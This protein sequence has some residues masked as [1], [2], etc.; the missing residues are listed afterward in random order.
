MDNQAFELRR[1]GL[2]QMQGQPEYIDLYSAEVDGLLEEIKADPDADRRQAHE[3]RIKTDCKHQIAF[4]MS[5]YMAGL[6]NG[7]DQHEGQDEQ[8][9]QG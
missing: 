1:L 6:A 9:M 4:L 3:Q 5:L 7:E 8:T 2:R